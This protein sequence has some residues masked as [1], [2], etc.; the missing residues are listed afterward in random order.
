MQHNEASVVVVHRATAGQRASA[1]HAT[2]PIRERRA[3]PN[4]TA[5]SNSDRPDIAVE[6]I[7]TS[8]GLDK[9]EI[10]RKLGRGKFGFT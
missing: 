10:Y 5:R 7:W 4:G 6:V 8:G 1:Y 3:P 2:L 9:L